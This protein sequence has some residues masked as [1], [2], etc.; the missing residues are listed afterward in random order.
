MCDGNIRNTGIVYLVWFG[1][2]DSSYWMHVM[3]YVWNHGIY[4]I[5]AMPGATFTNVD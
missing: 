2:I 5:A 1:Y 4:M 3:Y